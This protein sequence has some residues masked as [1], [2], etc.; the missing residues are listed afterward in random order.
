MQKTGSS[1]KEELQKTWF[2]CL[3]L[4]CALFLPL[5]AL[6]PFPQL[7]ESL[8]YIRGINVIFGFY[9]V[10][11]IVYYIGGWPYLWCVVSLGF[12]VFFISKLNKEKNKKRFFQIFILTVISIALNICWIMFCISSNLHIG[13]P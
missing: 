8:L 10:A 3:L 1:N 5:I 2:Y 9:C 11:L 13:P 4:N 6:A 12:L 7:Y